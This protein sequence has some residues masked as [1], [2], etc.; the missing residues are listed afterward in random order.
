VQREFFFAHYNGMAGV[1]A[2]IVANNNVA[3]L[4]EDIHNLALAFIAPLQS[5]H[6][7]IHTRPL[8]IRKNQR[9]SRNETIYGLKRK[10]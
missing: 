8:K 3:I 1:G 4:G 6:T 7:P 10:A 9:I 5:Y 2:S